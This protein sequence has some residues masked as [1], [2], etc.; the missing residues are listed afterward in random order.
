[1]DDHPFITRPLP[2]AAPLPPVPGSPN[3]ASTPSASP[4]PVTAATPRQRTWEPDLT[5]FWE[6]AA[7]DEG[8]YKGDY[9][10]PLQV[11]INQAGGAIVLWFTR[12]PQHLEGV[13]PIRLPDVARGANSF[14]EC[15][16]GVAAALIRDAAGG[17]RLPSEVTISW[18]AARTPVSDPFNVLDPSHLYLPPPKLHVVEGNGTLVQ[19][20][21]QLNLSFESTKRYTPLVLNRVRL[22]ARLPRAVIDTVPQPLRSS[23]LIDSVR[24]IPTTLERRMLSLFSSEWARGGEP[25]LDARL[26]AWKHAPKSPPAQ[27]DVIRSAIATELHFD[28]SEPW[29]SALLDRMFLLA[30]TN[31]LRVDDVTMT[32]SAW[33]TELIDDEAQAARPQREQ[34]SR[35]VQ[36]ALRAL[37]VGKTSFAYTLTFSDLGVAGKVGASNLGSN[38]SRPERVAGL[39]LGGY[40]VLVSVSKEKLELQR[41]L[42]GRAK[43]DDSGRPLIRSRTKAPWDGGGW[44]IGLFGRIDAGLA[45]EASRAGF[46]PAAD[47]GPSMGTAELGKIELRSDRDLP[48]A[49]AL[50]LATFT[51]SSF[52]LGQAKFGNWAKAHLVNSSLWVLSLASGGRMS[53]IVEPEHLAGPKIANWGAPGTTKWW[54]DWKP[55]A[56]AFDVGRISFGLGALTHFGKADQRRSPGMS[57]RDLEAPLTG[58][59]DALFDYD[60]ALLEDPTRPETAPVSR[61]LRLEERIAELRALLSMRGPPLLLLGFTSPEGSPEYN[62]ALSHARV[63]TI[64]Q[65]IRDA[66]G[67]VYVRPPATLKPLGEG[68]SRAPGRLEEAGVS[69]DGGGLPDPEKWPSRAAYLLSREGRLAVI[70]PR[71]RRVE[72]RAEGVLL[73]RI[74]VK[75]E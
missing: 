3:L 2:P 75:P 68:P 52:V 57:Q 48:G 19:N 27:R 17:Q 15:E 61:R 50:H 22:G 6:A 43:Y 7:P 46:E 64:E 62:Q 1:M 13:R 9:N 42:A 18:L 34:E 14:T 70:W 5:G 55:T 24:P 12:P 51:V 63:L 20:G 73:I 11:Q 49:S 37:G 74:L 28:C 16:Y 53:T 10:S 4:P 72:V 21:S 23:L 44:L 45:L 36:D 8:N 69:I 60:R 54:K 56:L 65:A 66:L 39:G 67:A 26:R 38:P 35:R 31:P 59:V 47:K 32:Y 25:R 71:W 41:D 29:R 40:P 58:E 33:L 30:D